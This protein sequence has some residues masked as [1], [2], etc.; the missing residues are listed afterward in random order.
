MTS[1]S[2]SSSRL[3]I[4]AALVALNACGG[5]ST[6][7]T[8]QPPPPPPVATT[9]TLSGT[10]TSTSG[11]PIAGATVRIG[12]GPN[13][14]RSTTTSAAGTY[15]LATLTAS[16]F[17]ASASATNFVSL[18][19]GVNL[20]SSQ[21]VD[22]QLAPTPLFTQSG[23]GNSV[24]DM[25]TTVSR[26]RIV[27]TYTGAGSNFIVRIGGR[28]VVNEII[29]TRWPSTVSDGTYLTSGGTV[30]ITNSAGVVWTFTEVR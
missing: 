30:E 13:S 8:T 5:S 6:A 25:P 9:F 3:I 16:G 21:T 17:T 1:T 2:T 22:F 12:D 28:L 24:F 29:G 19:K 15:S 26:V 23:E 10:V 11:A 7:P 14:G 27:G 18:G 4:L 20:T